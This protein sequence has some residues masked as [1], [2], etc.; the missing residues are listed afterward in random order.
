A[1][2]ITPT[3][4]AT[5]LQ[6]LT[7][8]PVVDAV[9]S[10]LHQ[11]QLNV[12]G[13][14]QGQTNVISVTAT[15]HSPAKAAQVANAYATEFV[16][17]ETSV[18]LK[19][20]TTAEVQLQAQINALEQELPPASGTP[21]G[22]AL[23]NQLA[24]LK[25]QYA[26]Y[27]VVG[28]QT[29]GGVTVVSPA[30]VPTAPSSPK[31]TE[32][33]LLGLAVGLLVG[34][35]AAFTA[36]SLDDKIRSK[37]DIERSAPNFPVMALVP[38]VRTWRDRAMPVVVTTTEPTSP[39][40]EAYRSLRTSLQFASYDSPIG[41]ILVTSP[42]TAE[43]KT[44]TVANLGVVLAQV[45]KEVVLVSADL[46]RPRLAAFFGLDEKIGLTSIMIGES[47]LDDAVQLVPDVPGLALLGCGPVPPNPTELLSSPKFE[48][49][50]DELKGH[51]DVVLI[52]S[53]PLIP[54]TDPVLLSRLTDMTLLVV[55]AGQTT[56]GQLR[57]GVEQL[58]RVGSKHV[59]IVFNEVTREE[60]DAY[61]YGYSYSSESVPTP[62]TAPT[63]ES[64]I[65]GSANLWSAIPESA[66]P[67][68]A[69][70]NGHVDSPEPNRGARATRRPRHAADVDVTED[71]TPAT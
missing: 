42:T 54:V 59:G 41:S 57:R 32:L 48:Q 29:T 70:P 68:T 38:M 5:E 39:V 44:S 69:M 28:T 13:A 26:Q 40:A 30:S 9:K 36:E 65:P 24:V 64:A 71:E 16:N 25:E 50:L 2:T 37:D 33:G 63:P 51:F 8:A 56:K 58:A 43:G 21:Q 22:L 45:G 47:T 6:L 62:S 49:I 7:S 52:D 18:A 17:Y 19:S 66:I 27:Q 55:A 61:G 31:K 60:D 12:K 53:S 10:R 4:V 34:L 20:L 23:A 67:P 15:D 11:S 1:Q 14:Q 46:R 3:Q 35:G